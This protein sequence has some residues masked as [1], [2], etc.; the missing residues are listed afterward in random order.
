M[1]DTAAP[2]KPARPTQKRVF[3][4]PA[5]EEVYVRRLGAAVLACW[6]SVDPELKQKILSEAASAW[7]REYNTD[8]LPAKLEAFIKRHPGRVG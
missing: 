5:E 8:K 2:P 7:D 4:Y 6:G 3:K 1:T